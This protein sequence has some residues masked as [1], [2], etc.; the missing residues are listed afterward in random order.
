[1]TTAGRIGR[2]GFLAVLPAAFCSPLV[3][4]AAARSGDWVQEGDQEVVVAATLTFRDPVVPALIERLNHLARAT[5]AEPGCLRYE[6]AL[7]LA[8]GHSVRL[9][10]QW[11]DLGALQAH[12]HTPHMI[13]FRL[14]LAELELLHSH[15]QA[16]AVD[17]ELPFWPPPMRR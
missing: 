16:F 3:P 5:R 9:F 1:M 10:E 14:Q 4:S 2:R 6:P 15:I 11:R 7:D 12:F 8:D 17:R 13:E